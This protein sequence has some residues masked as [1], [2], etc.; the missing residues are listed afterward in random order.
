MIAIIGVMAVMYAVFYVA[1]GICAAYGIYNG[2]TR[3]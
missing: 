2:I 1:W 3:R